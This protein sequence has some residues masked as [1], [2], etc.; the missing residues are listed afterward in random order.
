MENKP[1][2]LEELI[3]N[4]RQAFDELEPHPKTWGKIERKMFGHSGWPQ[5]WKV[6]A[7]IFFGAT[8]GLLIDRIGGGESTGY[9]TDALAMKEFGAVEQ[10]YSQV[11]TEKEALIHQIRLKSSEEEAM[12]HDLQKLDAMYEVLKEEF[13]KNPSKKVA[14]ALI[15][16]MLV[17]IDLLNQQLEFLEDHTTE[18]LPAH[19]EGSRI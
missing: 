17:R 19:E 8:V 18:P 9:T 15:L 10:F 4:H 6:A 7:I 14:D 12:E 5:L 2:S 11:I 3:Q 13:R 1:K 16:N